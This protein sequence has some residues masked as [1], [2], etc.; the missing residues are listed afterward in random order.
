VIINKF[1]GGDSPNCRV[2]VYHSEI[3]YNELEKEI[4]NFNK[5]VHYG[6]GRK[7]A[8]DD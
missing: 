8:V 3:C 4:R 6:T 7:G 2:K 1:A 5:E